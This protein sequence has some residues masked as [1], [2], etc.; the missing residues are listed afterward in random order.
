MRL[1]SALVMIA[2]CASAPALAGETE[3]T[4]AE[5]PGA[6]W[7]RARA[8]MVGHGFEL[9]EQ[10]RIRGRLVG[11]LDMPERSPYEAC[12]DQGFAWDASWGVV[13]IDIAPSGSGA[14]AEAHGTFWGRVH[15]Q[16]QTRTFPCDTTGKLEAELI[17][18]I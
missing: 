16:Q 10:D 11:R 12:G 2:I 8:A 17:G 13:S 5:S 18:A 4:F 3:R 6:V 1:P 9:T 15:F 7:D 14:A